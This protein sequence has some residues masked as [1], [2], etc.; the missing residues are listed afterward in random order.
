[1]QVGVKVLIEDG[2]GKYLLLH[3]SPLKYPDVKGGR[4]DIVGGRINPGETLMENLRREV[5]E[6]IGSE[7]VGT[8]K[9]VA[10]QDII[11]KGR[12][13]HAVRLT[14]RGRVNSEITLD[15][16]ENDLYRWHTREELLQLD[17]IDGYLK[18][19]LDSGVLV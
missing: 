8:P 7:L 18:E 15:T 4:W 2:A 16:S 3:R 12:D 19:L 1:M 13:L 5:R 6:E 14:Y 9:L 10:A 17:D 11:P